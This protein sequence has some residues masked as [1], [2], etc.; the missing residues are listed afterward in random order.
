MTIKEFLATA[1]PEGRQVIHFMAWYFP[2][3]LAEMLAQDEAALKAFLD[4]VPA[5]PDPN[6]LCL[7]ERKAAPEVFQML[8]RVAA[9]PPDRAFITYDEHAHL[10]HSDFFSGMSPNPFTGQIRLLGRDIELCQELPPPEEW[11]EHEEPS[12]FRF[13]YRRLKP[14][15]QPK[16]DPFEEIERKLAFARRDRSGDTADLVAALGAVGAV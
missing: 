8:R 12:G 11:F 10:C 3:Q 2:K 6:R 1:R 14:G 15:E 13:R 5:D 9:G 7:P 16:P 4:S